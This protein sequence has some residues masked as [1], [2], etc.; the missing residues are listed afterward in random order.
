M[1]HPDGSTKMGFEYT[2]VIPP[3]LQFDRDAATGLFKALAT[4]FDLQSLQFVEAGAVLSGP[5]IIIDIRV[6]KALSIRSSFA[7][8]ITPE[9]VLIRQV[10]E[11][12]GQVKAFFHIPI[13]ILPQI[14][15]R[16][17]W[18][19]LEE[20]AFTFLA[21]RTSLAEHLDLTGLG[22]SVGVGLRIVATQ[23]NVNHF[24]IHVEPYFPNP[25]NVYVEVK[26][27]F[28]QVLIQDD[29]DPV[30]DTIRRTYATLEVLETILQ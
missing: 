19:C 21:R 24:D 17:V 4:S 29:V 26:G 16:A 25:A 6:G 18:P 5:H 11:I 8:Q 14:E 2:L 30:A 22:P 13:L 20:D 27:I 1:L 10:K 3:V 12:V 15:V 9:D 28:P 23:D 7:Q